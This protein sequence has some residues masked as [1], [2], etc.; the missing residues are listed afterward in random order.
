MWKPV[1]HLDRCRPR[2]AVSW[3][4]AQ[5]WAPLS[6]GPASLSKLLESRYNLRVFI[7]KNQ[8]LFSWFRKCLSISPVSEPYAHWLVDL[9]LV[10]KWSEWNIPFICVDMHQICSGGEKWYNVPCTDIKC[11]L[12]FLKSNLQ[13]GTWHMVDTDTQVLNEWVK[14][15]ERS[16]LWVGLIPESWYRSK[17]WSAGERGPR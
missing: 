17:W 15:K 12:F 8:G 6:F 9:F 13:H 16:L 2:H 14:E 5:V 7:M 4:S 10:A 3:C 1:G 11:K